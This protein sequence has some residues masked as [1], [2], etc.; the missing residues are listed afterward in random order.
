MCHEDKFIVNYGVYIYMSVYSSTSGMFNNVQCF[1]ASVI[2]VSVTGQFNSELEYKY[3]L[4][5]C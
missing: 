1:N 4:Y 3:E 2:D 5:N